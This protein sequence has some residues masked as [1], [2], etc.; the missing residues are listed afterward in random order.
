MLFE[1]WSSPA[2]ESG[3]KAEWMQMPF[4]RTVFN[5]D[6][7]LCMFFLLTGYN[8]AL[9]PIKTARSG[10]LA[11]AANSLMTSAFRK[12]FRFVLPTIVAL[13]INWTVAQLGCFDLA[14]RLSSGEDWLSWTSPFPSHTWTIAIKDFVMAIFTVWVAGN[15]YYDKNYWAL[16]PLLKA[17]FLVFGFLLVT[18]R[19]APK[20]RIL[21]ALVM[22]LF[23]FKTLDSTL[24][25]SRHIP[26]FANCMSSF[27]RDELVWRYSLSRT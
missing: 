4:F 17:S 25:S 21:L 9:K 1:K 2:N 27:V 11:A 18:L 23:S 3:G 14:H 20:Y 15:V 16:G 22:Y 26:T 12:P 19:C 5:G 13:A 8:N 6:A 24:T 7:W 10:D